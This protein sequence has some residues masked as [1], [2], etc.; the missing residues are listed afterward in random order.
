[1]DRERRPSV[2]TKVLGDII[3]NPFGGHEDE[4][5]GI[6]CAD[7][8]KVIDKLCPLLEVAANFDNLL[9]VVVGGQLHRSDVDLDHVLEEIL[10]YDISFWGEVVLKKYSRWRASGHPWA[11]WH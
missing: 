10:K 4:H 3:R 7:F 1:M 11:M 2:L 8:L 5:L 9:D 6:L